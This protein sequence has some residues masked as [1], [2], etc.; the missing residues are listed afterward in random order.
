MATA[1]TSDYLK[2]AEIARDLNINP[3]TPVRW[4]NRGVVLSDGTVIRLKH[5]RLPGGIRVKPEDLDAFL[6][7]ITEDR[8]KS[9]AV[10]DG[11]P[12]SSR[13]SSKRIATMRAGLAENGF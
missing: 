6:T 12:M 8:T 4:A 2:P 11:T 1:S 13:T 9:P 5:T 3:A 10:K 7:A